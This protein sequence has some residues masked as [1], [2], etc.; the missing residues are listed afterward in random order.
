[1]SGDP[2]DDPLVAAVRGFNRFYTRRIGVLDEGH[3]E[4]PFSLAEVRVLYELAHRDRPL[5]S[6]LARDL[7]LDAGYLS[8]ML[9]GFRGRGLVARTASPEDARQSRLALTAKGRQTFAPL[10]R[11]ASAAVAEM[12]RPL[13][14]EHRTR[15]A[16]AMESIR[17]ILEPRADAGE[18]YT[19]RLHR[20]GDMGWVIHRHAVLYAREYGWDERFEALVAEIAARFIQNFDPRRE[21]CWIAEQAGEPV[22]SVF[23]VK[24]SEE[25]A[26][27][28]LL[29]V[30]P[31]ARGSGLGS[32]L[33]A[34]CVAFARQTG[35]RSIVLWTQSILHAAQHI[36]RKAGFQLTREEHHSEFGFP[37][38]GQTWELQ[39]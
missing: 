26:R 10:E 2:S 28:R 6:E 31:A 1:M 12:L 25:V 19:L 13:T 39:L 38:T 37:L 16:A 7:G 18:G 20:A 36:Y 3:L 23:L 21:R 35:Y 17:G 30:E 24:E 33:V 5:A 4:S 32:R 15:L 14:D 9:R 27:L 34:E 22:G 8:R 29:L 11:R